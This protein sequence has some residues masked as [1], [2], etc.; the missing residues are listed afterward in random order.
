MFVL[1]T[2]VYP[3]GKP[4]QNSKPVP[5]PPYFDSSYLRTIPGMLKVVQLVL[6]LTA[7]ILASVGWNFSSYYIVGST[8]WTRFA[9]MTGFLN[10]MIQLMLYLFHMVAQS[11]RRLFWE[12]LLYTIL[13]ILLFISG[14]LMIP[15]ANLDG[16]RVACTVFCWAGVVAYGSDA[17]LQLTAVRNARPAEGVEQL[18]HPVSSPT[19]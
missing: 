10:T 12:F 1:Q 15:Y 16:S 7:F 14:I 8:G 3:D 17:Y 5:V 2:N 6:T 18:T 11:H 4:A 19:A 9:T 13:A